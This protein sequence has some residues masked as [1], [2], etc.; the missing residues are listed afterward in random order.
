[1]NKNNIKIDLYHFHL[2]TGET[3]HPLFTERKKPFRD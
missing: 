3:P 1:M 2:F